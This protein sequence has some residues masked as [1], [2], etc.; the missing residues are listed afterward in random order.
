[1]A[2]R[3]LLA[4]GTILAV[5]GAS[6]W[7]ATLADDS[8]KSVADPRFELNVWRKVLATREEDWAEERASAIRSIRSVSDPRAAPILAELWDKENETNG[9]FFIRGYYIEPLIRIGN[10]PAFRKLAEI[11]VEDRSWENRG[12]AAKWIGAQDNRDDAIPIYLRYL[13][14]K[15]FRPQALTALDYAQ[16]ASQGKRPPN[17][18]LVAA[19]IDNL[20][21]VTTE[22]R[23]ISNGSSSGRRIFMDGSGSGAFDRTGAAWQVRETNYKSAQNQVAHDLL[24]Q[25]TLDDYGFDQQAWRRNVLRLP[26]KDHER[27]PPSPALP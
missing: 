15:D 27:R 16:I 4:L 20:I 2:G 6:D 25:Y 10:G 1:M 22:R 9:S 12:R 19:L 8:E 24:C 3:I 18:Q 23:R 14:T 21:T 13:G 26:S 5:A 11:S 17:R 7:S